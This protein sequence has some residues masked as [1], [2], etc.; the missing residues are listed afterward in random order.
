MNKTELA[1]S[2]TTIQEF[3]GNLSGGVGTQVEEKP[4]LDTIDSPTLTS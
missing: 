2:F 4:N 1:K 3:Q